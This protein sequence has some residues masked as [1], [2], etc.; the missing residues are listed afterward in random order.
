MCLAQ[1]LGD[2]RCCLHHCGIAATGTGNNQ[3]PLGTLQCCGDC[4]DARLQLRFQ[5]VNALSTDQFRH[6]ET[7]PGNITR[8]Q[9][10][11]VLGDVVQS[12]VCH[13]GNKQWAAL[14]LG[15]VA[16]GRILPGFKS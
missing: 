13:S 9:A 6:G 3:G 8:R 16:N 1:G 10:D 4:L 2:L 7:Q 14:I 5:L 11:P 12:A 15:E